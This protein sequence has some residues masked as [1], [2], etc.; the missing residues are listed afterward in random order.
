MKKIT[1]L[2]LILALVLSLTACAAQPQQT[3]PAPSQT[4]PADGSVLGEGATVFPF[5]VRDLDGSEITYEI[6]TDAKIVG[7]ALMALG[8][9]AGTQGDYGL[10][11]K[12]VCG[13]QADYDVDKSY[14]AFYVNGEY[15]LSGVDTTEITADTAYAFVRTK[16]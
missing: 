16:D 14:W 5:T 7:E 10:Y 6:H 8:L 4:F 9:I 11:V 3:D 15:A 12:E 1:V 2:F 13:I